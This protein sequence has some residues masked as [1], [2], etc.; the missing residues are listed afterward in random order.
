MAIKA[1][2]KVEGLRELQQ[3][4]NDRVEALKRVLDMKILQLAEEAVTHA[5]QNKGYKDRTANL[6]NS[7]SFALYYDGELVTAKAGQI[8][9]PDADPEGQQQVETALDAY[10]S[11]EGII[12]PKGYSL[13]IVAGMR[14]GAH[15]EHK[16]FNVLYLTKY[17]LRDEMRKIL[18][19]AID[20]VKNGRI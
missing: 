4:L 6:K 1:E 13:I 9:M 5:K 11:Q 12:A 17:F 18:E 3:R 19:E 14:Y 8:P 2:F 15:V 20:D 7:I 10:A 16:G